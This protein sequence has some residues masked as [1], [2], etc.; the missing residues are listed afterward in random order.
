MDQVSG[1]RPAPHSLAKSCSHTHVN[2]KVENC[3][4]INLESQAIYA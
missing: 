4:K 2:R 3:S 1:F